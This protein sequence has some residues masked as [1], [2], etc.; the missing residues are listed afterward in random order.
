MSNHKKKK[1]NKLENRE[2]YENRKASEAQ[3]DTLITLGMNK[4]LVKNFT[5]REANIYIIEYQKEIKTI[6]RITD[7]QID[8]LI[9]L[10][11]KEEDV[12]DFSKE[13]ARE[14]IEEL[15]NKV[16]PKQFNFLKSLGMKTWEIE[17]LSKDEATKEIARRLELKDN[18]L[19]EV[20]YEQS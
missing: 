5:S 6:D 7:K 11:M 3:I 9:V 14:K 1:H 15:K 10:G 13:K 19:I 2:F 8:F 20:M 4:E 18:P 16:S 17:K 12:K